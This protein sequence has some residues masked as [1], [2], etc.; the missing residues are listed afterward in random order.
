[1][2]SLFHLNLIIHSLAALL[3]LFQLFS[4]CLFEVKW[5]HPRLSSIYF[6]YLL[7][8]HHQNQNHFTLIFSILQVF[9]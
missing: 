7:K 8:N 4:D 2:R 5:V 3:F 9:L 1:M 6:L